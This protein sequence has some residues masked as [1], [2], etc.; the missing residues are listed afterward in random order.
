VVSLSPAGSFVA[1]SLPAPPARSLAAETDPICDD[2]G[3]AELDAALGAGAVTEL[4][5]PDVVDRA[6]GDG[7]DIAGARTDGLGKEGVRAVG[8]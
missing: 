7:V 2:S 4:G 6:P 1:R 8:V 3:T 5:V